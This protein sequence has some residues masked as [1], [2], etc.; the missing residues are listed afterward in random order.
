MLDHKKLDE[1]SG[2]TNATMNL[3][4]PKL[5]FENLKLNDFTILVGENSSGKSFAQK[6]IWANTFALNSF[7]NDYIQKTSLFSE[8]SKEEFLEF[9]L[10]NTFDD[11]DFT[12]KIRFYA[13]DKILDVPYYILEYKLSN[14]KISDLFIDFPTNVK[15]A[16]KPIYMSKQTR[17]FE[18]ITQYL[19]TKSIMGIGLNTEEEIKEICELYKLYDVLAMEELVHKFPLVG[20]LLNSPLIPKEIMG[21]F[22]V[23]TIYYNKDRK[24]ICYTDSSDKERNITTLGDGHQAMLIMLL[25]LVPDEV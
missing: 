10:S 1:F 17:Q 22:D 15:S 18:F 6:I 13:Q 5:S 16:T 24:A 11:F 9:L 2:F 8:T 4:N 21:D 25:G 23:K 19:N 20:K 14:G 12:G 7:I 3:E